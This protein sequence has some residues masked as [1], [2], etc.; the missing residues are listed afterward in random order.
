MCGVSCLFAR[1]CVCSLACIVLYLF[2][3]VWCHLRCVCLHRCVV[4]L[5]ALICCVDSDCSGVARCVCSGV[6]CCLFFIMQC[7]SVLSLFLSQ[8]VPYRYQLH[9]LRKRQCEREVGMEQNEWEGIGQWMHRR[10]NEWESEREDGRQ[11]ER[12]WRREIPSVSVIVS[13]CQTLGN[14]RERKNEGEKWEGDHGDERMYSD[15][16]KERAR[17]LHAQSIK[18]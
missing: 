16:G 17:E 2:A 14:E 10:E 6:L 15:R 3:L 11:T 7:M 1:C 5:M 13:C 18:D 4:L 12:N 8:R 9:P